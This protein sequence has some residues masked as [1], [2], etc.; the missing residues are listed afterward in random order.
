MSN[1]IN[2]S[3]MFKY[4]ALYIQCYNIFIDLFREKDHNPNNI[5]TIF[6]L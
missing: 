3:I 4:F 5:V 6:N 1:R 2:N